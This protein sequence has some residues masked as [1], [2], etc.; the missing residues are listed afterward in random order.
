MFFAHA[1]GFC[2]MENRNLFLIAQHYL[3]D[4]H[5]IL[6][7]PPPGCVG[8]ILRLRLGGMRESVYLQFVFL[9]LAISTPTV[10]RTTD[11]VAFLVAPF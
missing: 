4:P 2:G 7:Y 9:F 11:L 3:I 6:F 10:T 5:H 1:D 8:T